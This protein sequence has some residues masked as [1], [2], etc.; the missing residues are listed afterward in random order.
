MTAPGVQKRLIIPSEGLPGSAEAGLCEIDPLIGM[1]VCDLP[2]AK[3]DTERKTKGAPQASP[4]RP[5]GDP[6]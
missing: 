1:M 2:F 4:L 3:A 5:T 6:K